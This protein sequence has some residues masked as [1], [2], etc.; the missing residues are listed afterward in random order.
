MRICLV[1]DNLVGYHEKWSGGELVVQYLASLLKRQG[2]QV[3][4]L[5]LRSKKEKPADVFPVPALLGKFWFFKKII[6]LHILIR[7]LAIFF[8][9]KKIKPD[10]IHLF[11]AN[12]LF[13]PT[14]LASLILK[15]PA[16]FTVLD[17]NIICPTGHLRLKD[18]NI[19][20]EQEGWNCKKCVSSPKF[21]E[22]RVEAGLAKKLKQLITFTET[23]RKRLISHGFPPEK[24]KVK[25]IY[26]FS[27]DASRGKK[28]S[29]LKNNDILFVGTFFKQKGLHIV[30]EAMSYVKEKITD[31]KLRVIGREEGK[32]KERIE[33]LIRKL[34][35]QDAVEFL[36]QKKNEETLKIISQSN[37]AVVAEQW[38][39]DFGPVALVEAMAQ[40]RPVVAGNIGSA[41]D[42]IK[43]GVNGLLAEY[44]NPRQFSEKIIFLLQN[45]QEA[46][47]M[48]QSARETIKN[49]FGQ[50]HVQEVLELYAK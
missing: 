50:N 8:L 36:G 6:P 37:L 15:I 48:G 29:I 28:E 35:L 1:S 42:F 2:Q 3:F 16:T 47:E 33:T 10:I 22:R 20:Q 40:A 11:H 38:F 26:E 23:S 12:S 43:D 5:T 45:K 9:L 19:C 49:F 14:M 39:S 34:N 44:N 18:G 17:Y 24:V 32:E 13:L 4:V 46:E 41:S 25:Y 7:T 27:F 21:L 31:A 30:I